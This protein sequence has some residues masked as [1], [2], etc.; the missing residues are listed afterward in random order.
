MLEILP[1]KF[2]ILITKPGTDFY[3]K[4][5]TINA[6]DLDAA[7]HKQSYLGLNGAGLSI[8][9]EQMRSG[10]I[11]DVITVPEYNEQY[12]NVFVNIPESIAKECIYTF[13]DLTKDEKEEKL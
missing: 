10:I 1:E 3:I 11:K 8:D 7:T 5:R 13:I 6:K 9:I 12:K 4:T 2:C